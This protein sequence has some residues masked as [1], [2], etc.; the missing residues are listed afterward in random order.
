LL[1]LQGLS[2]ELESP[3]S[4]RFLFVDIEEKAALASAKKEAIF[5]ENLTVLWFL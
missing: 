2:V 3:I 1:K 5:E 4:R